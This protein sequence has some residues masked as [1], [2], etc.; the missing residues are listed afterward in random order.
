MTPN[1]TLVLVAGVLVAT[2]VYLLLA[3]SISR[4][5]LGIVLLSN[6]ANLLFLVAAGPAG[7]GAFVG[8]TPEDEMTDP[9]PQALVLTAIVITLGMT[10]FILAM[11]HRSWQLSR[12]DVVADDTE[13]LR[14]MELAVRDAS[15]H[16][17]ETDDE[18]P[19]A[20]TGVAS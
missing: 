13:D 19:D 11:A 18:T 5:L 15:P 12:T 10:A 2:G 1:L 3:R 17:D 8:L 6:G 14:L 9:L 20:A 7:E 4:A 16:T